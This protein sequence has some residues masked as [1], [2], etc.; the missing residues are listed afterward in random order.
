MFVE[1]QPTP[2][3]V[4]FD[5]EGPRTDLGRDATDVVIAL[6]VVVIIIIVDSSHARVVWR[7]YNCN[8]TPSSVVFNVFLK[9]M[10]K[11]LHAGSK[12]IRR[13]IHNLKQIAV[14]GASRVGVT[15]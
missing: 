11:V 10:A 7:R 8:P 2:V 12:Q 5:V 1:A 6:V 14:H 15:L 9:K 13:R 3:P 4:D